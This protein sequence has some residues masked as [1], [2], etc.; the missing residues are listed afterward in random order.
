[1]SLRIGIGLPAAVPGMAATTV[2]Q[3]AVESE[4]LGFRS[5]GVHDRLVYDN[6]DALVALTA[7]AARTERIEL[8][9]TVLNL[10]YRR[11]AVVLA[12]QLASLDRLS[13][14]RLAVG[15]GLGLWPDDY[16]A[17]EIPLAGRGAG[18]ETKLVT[19]RRVW[20]GEV[21]GAAGLIPALVDG[22]PEVMFAGM[23]PTTFARIAALGQG[24]VAPAIG[25]SVF[26]DG[27]AAVRRAW[28]AAGRE[29]QPRVVVLRYF[30]LGDGADDV[31]DHY[32]ERYYG[33]QYFPLVRADTLTSPE[34]LRQELLRL[35]EAGSDD[36]ILFPCSGDLDQVRLLAAALDEIG[37]GLT[38]SAPNRE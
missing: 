9:T 27:I 35:S 17:C 36:L 26:T 8:L 37:A 12:K 7:A 24:W 33:P 22:R 20:G 16:A 4:R 28:T 29:G 32:L 1:V 30:C 19:M 34:H 2:G 21:T 18:F 31:A 38:A 14:G 15:L 23:A 3:W 25:G 5:L 11:D 10:G 13:G 6:L